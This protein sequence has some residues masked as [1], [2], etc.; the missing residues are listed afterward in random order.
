MTRQFLVPVQL[1]ADP[2][3]P[4]EAAPKQ[5]IDLRAVP[6]GGL[7]NQRLVKASS[8][9]YDLAWADAAKPGSSASSSEPARVGHGAL[10]WQM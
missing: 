7:L 1:P 8:T 6:P 2:A 3:N 9:S 10:G 4:L 5:Y